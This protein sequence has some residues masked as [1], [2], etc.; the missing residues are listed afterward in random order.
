MRRVLLISALALLV[1]C[2]G[3][4][5]EDPVMRLSATESLEQG[6]ALLE[7]EKYRE[8]KKYLVHA[9]E[10]EP[11]S[12]AGREGLL[13][14]ADALFL[15]GGYDAWAEAE[16]R[17]RDFLNRF[18]TSPRADYAQYRVAQCLAR[19]M[20]KPNRDQEVTRKALQALNELARAHPTSEYVEASQEELRAVQDNL[21]EHEF[22][23]GKYYLRVSGGSRRARRL[24]Q[25]AV[26][27]FEYL[28]DNYPDYTEK[29]KVLAGLCLAH[30][31]V[32]EPER[33]QERCD[34]LRTEFPDSKHRDDVPKQYR[35]GG[36]P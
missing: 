15:D 13:L 22:I 33:A 9:F 30:H 24:A 26:S 34:Q 12:V 14:A 8:A 3:L 11:N 4:R 29:D 28:L 35:K 5:R 1:A 21:A 16:G 17:Y 32:E 36:S 27:R 18:P 31:R 25:A 10:V 23:V 6:K 19:R 20:E 2:A 7:A